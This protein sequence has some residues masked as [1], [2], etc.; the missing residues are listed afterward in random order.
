VD[1]P[2]NFHQSTQL[3]ISSSDGYLKDKN[4]PQVWDDYALESSGCKTN[5]NGFEKF[6]V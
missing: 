5:L 6:M 3:A 2:L 4:M 1:V